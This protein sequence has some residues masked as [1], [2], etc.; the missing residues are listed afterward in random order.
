MI[1]LNDAQLKTVMTVAVDIAPEKR[2][3]FLER[4]GAMLA[5]R[6][7]AAVDQ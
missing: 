6:G 3:M 5:I 7:V 4:V 1:S 2:S